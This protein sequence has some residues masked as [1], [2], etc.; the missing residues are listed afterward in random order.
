MIIKNASDPVKWVQSSDCL[1]M[2]LG[3][4]HRGLNERK[5]E[6]ALTMFSTLYGCSSVNAI[7]SSDF[8][9]RSFVLLSYLIPKEFAVLEYLAR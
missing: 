3:L 9:F 5:D 6:R 2:L 1:W 7:I 8:T 4:S